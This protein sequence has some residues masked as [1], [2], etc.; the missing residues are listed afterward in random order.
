MSVRTTPIG[1]YR[2]ARWRPC[3]TSS[4]LRSPAADI[5]L[6]V[7]PDGGHGAAESAYGNA[8]RAR[9][10]LEHLGPPR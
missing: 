10:L 5:S 2:R 6:V 7:I 8:R 3:F 4:S 1:Q 9:F